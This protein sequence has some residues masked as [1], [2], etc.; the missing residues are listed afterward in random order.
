MVVV[1]RRHG[2][3]VDI[4]PGA[5]GSRGRPVAV[6]I[7]T[8]GRARHPRHPRHPRRP[9]PERV[10]AGR[11]AVVVPRP[12]PVR[13]RAPQR[14]HRRR[15]PGVR[16][17]RSVA[18]RVLGGRTGAAG[19]APG[20][21]AGQFVALRVSAGAAARRVAR[22]RPRHAHHQL[23]TPGGRAVTAGRVSRPR[24][25]QRVGWVECVHLI[26]DAGGSIILAL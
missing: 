10:E 14:R 23:L 15:Q 11:R 3:A 25:R 20:A 22:P 21:G 2:S 18:A 17:A 1:G 4:R 9:V 19:V 24:A 12:R 16:D 5:P 7:V 26:H 8:V 13:A 6:D